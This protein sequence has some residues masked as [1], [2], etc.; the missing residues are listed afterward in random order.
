M[1]AELNVNI[2]FR[3]HTETDN[4]LKDVKLPDNIIVPP[5]DIQTNELLSIADTLITDY[6]SVFFDFI[7][8]ERP[9]IHYLYDVEEYTRNRGLNLTEDELPGIVAKTSEQLV[10]SV[11]SSFKDNKPRSSYLAAKKRFCPY[12]DGKSTER[13]VHWFFYGIDRGIN[14]VD[15]ENPVKSWLY[16]GGALS[17]ES[18]IDSLVSQL[19][20]LKQDDNAVSI[21]LKKGLAQ[22]K[23]RL[24]LLRKLKPSINLIVHAGVMPTTLEEAEAIKYFQSEGKFINKK[25]EGAYKQ[26]FA[27]E[28]R[29]LFGDSQFDQVFNYETNSNYW[30]ALQ[31]S[32]PT[33]S[34]FD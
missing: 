13:A 19:N 33:T 1:L 11:A 2:I 9:I 16:L 5:P 20:E 32:I 7:V 17:D 24:T 26:S 3:S 4:L 8:T 10:A 22:D 14:F 30:N 25:M 29:R 6:S 23:D 28:A 27:R 34:M 21:V 18:K 15:T 12:D 31:K